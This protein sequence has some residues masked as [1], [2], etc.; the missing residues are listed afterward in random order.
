VSI[1]REQL[2]LYLEVIFLRCLR[3]LR[4]DDLAQDA[5]QEVFASFYEQAKEKTIEKPLHYLYRSSTN[6]CLNLL[7]RHRRMLLWQGEGSEIAIESSV[8]SGI[9]VEEMTQALG[10]EA[11]RLMIYRYV[12]Q[13]TY[14]EIGEIFLCSDR[15]IKKRLDRLQAKAQEYMRL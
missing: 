1:E 13:M 8:E 15:A 11:M 12:D 4:D 9:L 10:E 3:I 5:L 2:S 14:E 6:H 7:R